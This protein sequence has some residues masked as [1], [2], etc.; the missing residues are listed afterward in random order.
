MRVDEAGDDDEAFDVAHHRGGGDLD[1]VDGADVDD[2]PL[3]DDEDADIDDGPTGGVDA[4]PAVGD[5]GV[6]LLLGGRLFLLTGAGGLDRGEG[7][8]NL[9]IG[10]RSLVAGFEEHEEEGERDDEKE[11]AARPAEHGGHGG[12]RFAAV[13][14]AA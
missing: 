3:V 11:G 10:E 1:G 4:G 14:C 5:G 13:F 9:V 12:F 2:L 8:L 7:V 6:V